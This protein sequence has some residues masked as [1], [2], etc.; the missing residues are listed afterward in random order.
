MIFRC[1]ASSFLFVVFS[2]TLNH[3]KRVFNRRRHRHAHDTKVFRDAEPLIG[4]EEQNH[5]SAQVPA[6]I[7]YGIKLHR[8]IND[9]QHT[10][11]AEQAFQRGAALAACGLLGF[12]PYQGNQDAQKIIHSHDANQKL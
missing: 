5:R 10:E 4:D 1:T 3:R 11:L 2:F 9:Q 8:D 12:V 6:G 7:G